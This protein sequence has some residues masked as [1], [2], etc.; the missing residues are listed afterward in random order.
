VPPVPLRSYQA[1]FFDFAGTLF[2]D[3][4]LR[5]VHLD[6]LHFVANEIGTGGHS[7]AELRAAYRQGMG[8]AFRTVAAVPCYLHR[9]LFAAAFVHTAK[10]LGGELTP[11]AAQ[12]AVDR[13]HLATAVNAEL[14]PGCLETMAALRSQGLHVGIVSN[15]DEALLSDMVER[16]GLSAAIDAWTSSEEAGS[17]K[18]DPGIY[19]HAMAKAGCGPE[20]ALFVGDSV[21]HDIEGPAALGMRTA[22]LVADAKPGRGEANPDFVIQ[23]LSEVVDIVNG[24]TA[25]KVDQR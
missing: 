14:R 11:A 3:R 7:D 25:V 2:S 9:D 15:I 8:V 6:Q 17:C 16:L 20:V 12:E 5:D 10:A 24:S 18:P 22:W 4:A 1:V 23:T 19:H 13:Q 21:S